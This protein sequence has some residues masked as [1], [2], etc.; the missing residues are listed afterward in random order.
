MRRSAAQERFYLDPPPNAQITSCSRARRPQSQ[1]LAWFC[2]ERCPHF[3]WSS[4]QCRTKIRTGKRGDGAVR[5]QKRA[6]KQC[7]LQCRSAFRVANQS[8][9]EPERNRIGRSGRRNAQRTKAFSSQ[10]LHRGEEARLLHLDRTH[11]RSNAANRSASIGVNRTRSPIESR[12]NSSR[13][14]RNILVGVRPSNLHPPGVANG[15]TP[16]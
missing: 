10:I 1:H 7:H 11:T 16:V 4:I 12:L 5:K 3:D 2:L 14:A 15:Y 13:S 9:P 6:R 8:I